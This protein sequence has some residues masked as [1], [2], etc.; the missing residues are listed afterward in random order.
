MKPGYAAALSHT[1]PTPSCVSPKII[2]V[3][4]MT[5]FRSPRLLPAAIAVLLIS[6]CNFIRDLTTEPA[7][8][9]SSKEMSLRR[10]I[11][12]YAQKYKG[13][14]YT[15]A[16]KNPS[17]GFDCSGFTSYVMQRFDI[18]LSPSSREQARQGRTKRLEEARPGDLIFFRRS[19][20]EPV[21]HVALVISSERQSIKVIHSTTSRGVV[22]DDLLSSSYWKPKIDTVRDVVTGAR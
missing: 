10:D 22:V 19:A 16:G 17:S 11:A 2:P 4:A 18:R 1:S 9:E 21:F 15:P 20:S 14:R 6:G 12:S 3:N 5:I 13:T 7:T 8:A